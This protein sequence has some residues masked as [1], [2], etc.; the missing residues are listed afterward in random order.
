MQKTIEAINNCGVSLSVWEKRNEDGT[1]SGLYDWT[2]M[3]GNEKKK[4]LRSLP[5]KFPQILDPEHCGTITQ[6]WKVTEWLK[7]Y[8]SLAG[9]VIGYENASVT[10]HSC[11]GLPPT[12]I[13]KG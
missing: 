2:S 5:E 11:L 6:I 4:V 9:D 10:I 3:V 7:L 8:L 12:P 13:C 1:P